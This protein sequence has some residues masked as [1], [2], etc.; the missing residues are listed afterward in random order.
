MVDINLGRLRAAIPRASLL[1]R[2]MANEE[3]RPAVIRCLA[4]PCL[5]GHDCIVQ[6]RRVAQTVYYSIAFEP[7]QA[8]LVTL[9]ELSPPSVFDRSAP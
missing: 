5:A 4:A 9:R 8:I 6:T 2:A 3:R 7:V 1:L